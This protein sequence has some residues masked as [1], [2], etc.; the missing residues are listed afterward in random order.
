MRLLTGIVVLLQIVIAA[1]AYPAAAEIP[2]AI[3]FDDLISVERIGSFAV[4]PDGK[5]VAFEVTRFNKN[6]NSSNTDIYLASVAGGKQWAFI[7]SDADDSSPAWSSDGKQIAFISDR[8]GTSQIWIIPVDGGEAKKITDVPTGVSSF[9][10][11]RNGRTIA[12]ASSVYPECADMACNAAKLDEAKN[13]KVKGRVVDELLFRHWSSWRNGKWSHIFITGIDGGPLVEVNTGRTDAPP[14]ALGGDRDFDFSPDGAELCFVMNPDSFPAAST[15]ND[16]YIVDAAGG[17][18]API[19][20]DNRGDDN[21]PR[22]SPDGRFIAYCAMP[23]PGLESDRVRLMLYDRKTGARTSLTENFDY[24]IDHFSWGNDS[25]TLYFSVEDKGRRAIGAVSIRGGDASLIIRGG[26]DTD[27]ATTPDGKYIVFARQSA[28]RPVDLYRATVKGKQIAPITD[29]NADLFAGLAMNPVEEYWY[30]GA[31]GA[32]IHCYVVKPPFYKADRKY[33]LILLIHGGPQGSFG[34]D[35]H[36]RW[37]SQMFASPGYVVA[38]VNPHGSTGYGD[39]FERE[40]SGDWGGAPFEDIL[41]GVDFLKTLPFVDRDRIAAA[42]ASYGGYMIDWLEGHTDGLFRCLVSHD[43]VYNLESMYGATEELWFPEWEFNGTPWTNPDM[44]ARWSPHRFAGSFK[45]PCLVVHSEL[46]YRVPFEEGLQFF[47]ALQ[48]Q[49]VPSKLLYFP[50][51]CH[52]V[53]KPLNAELWWKTL[54][55]WFA[56]YLK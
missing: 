41:K 8:D 49:G 43:G 11:S 25:K 51:E 33:P 22:Y 42:G 38:M 35:F 7:R 5:Q 40:I 45:T 47:T 21:N 13:S 52:F 3:T 23:T 54:H 1:I 24:S 39:A 34:D 31:L 32:K 17:K 53:Q 48:R 20:S 55:E 16:L 36:Y 29:L 37:N 28:T 26:Y 12:L 4:S 27:V 6:E 46:D 15:N 30:D 50:D 44:Y 18:A 14:L 56:E 19:T 10:L 2:R 9:I